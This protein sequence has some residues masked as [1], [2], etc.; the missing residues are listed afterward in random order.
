MHSAQLPLTCYFKWHTNMNSNDNPPTPSVNETPTIPEPPILE[1]KADGSPREGAIAAPSTRAASA[2]WAT[3]KPTAVDPGAGALWNWVLPITILMGLFV[4]SLYAATE[5]LNHWRKMNAQTEA[6][7]TYMKRRAELKAEAEHAEERLDLLD[8]RVRL[9]SLGF[10]EV[11][12][13]V[14]PVVVNVANYREPTEK[15]LVDAKAKRLTLVYDPDNDR[16]YVQYGVGSGL[17]FKPGAILT[18]HHV[19]RKAQRLRVAFPTGRSIGIDLAAAV[20]DVKTDLAII[21]LPETMPAAMKEEAQNRAEFA[22]SEKDVQVGEWVLA[23]GSPLGLRHTLTHG[24]I[25]AKGRLVPFREHEDDL[26]ELLQTDAAINPGN[27]G[28][29][30]FDQLGRVV[31]INVMIASETGGN[32]GI[33]FAIPSNTAKRIADLLL[34]KGEVP[35]GFLGISMEELAGPEAKALKIDDGAILVKTVVAGEAADK[36][37]IKPD[38]IIVRINKETLQRIKPMRHL[39]QIVADLEPGTEISIEIIRDE[40]RQQITLTLGKRPANLP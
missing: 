8:K 7:A 38:D 13:K 4:L 15:E 28:G 35:R 37:G 3:A 24:I 34:T 16:K 20:S 26:M 32:Q 12:R 5:V 11:A 2:K 33:G 9:T 40:Q 19:I 6:E 14:L 36:A 22:D 1:P 17:I 29:P 23:M 25:S 31:G 27:S 21:R 18:N 39:R 30:L 10:R